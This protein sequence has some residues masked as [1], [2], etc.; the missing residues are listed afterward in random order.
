MLIGT[1]D[2][3][4]ADTRKPNAN[5]NA[6]D[7]RARNWRR[8]L[9][10]YGQAA[11]VISL[12]TCVAWGASSIMAVTF[13]PF[14]FLIAILLLVTDVGINVSLLASFACF[15]IL[16]LFMTKGSPS[17]IPPE[18]E[19]FLS[20]SFF[21]VIG[22]VISIIDNRLHRQIK[23]TRRNAERT[24]A[25]YDFTKTVAAAATVEDIA[26]ATVERVALVLGARVVFLLAQHDRLEVTASV[27]PDLRL[28]TASM[29]AM[30]W[31]WRHNKPAGF[32]SDTLPGA[33]FFGLPLCVGENVRGVLALR[34]ENAAPLSP[35]QRH[36]LSSLT[37]QAAIAVERARLV[38][39]VA[40][41]K[42]QTETERL[43]AS[44]LSSVSHDL[45]A[46]LD[47]ITATAHHL[48]KDWEKLDESEQ[49]GLVESIMGEADRLDRF[50]QNLLDMTEIVTGNLRLNLHHTDVALD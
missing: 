26:K 7:I 44:L 29:A 39:D 21:L 37:D 13:L 38:T 43:R 40:Q 5:G 41:A 4:R 22:I 8:S 49:R 19:E 32:R 20:L 23:A 18:R 48:N 46:P 25:L 14:I 35:E 16:D 3:N 17:L 28:D 9:P 45:R 1:T 33:A 31:A 30:D 15:V 6:P 11:V 36:F 50:V 47:T 10:A 2:P 12:A 24:Q 27:P 34:T 42:L